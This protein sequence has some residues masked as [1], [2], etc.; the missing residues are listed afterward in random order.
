MMDTLLEYLYIDAMKRIW[1]GSTRERKAL[2][3]WNAA[4]GKDWGEIYNA[5]QLLAERQSEIAFLA[6][7]HLGLTLENTLWK[8]LDVLF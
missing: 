2:A 7:F 1:S 5:A 4:Q 3:E 6:G 8:Q